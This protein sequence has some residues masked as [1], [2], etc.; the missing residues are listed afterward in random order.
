MNLS[1]LLPAYNSER[2]LEDALDSVLQQSHTT[3]ELLAIDDGSTD[4]TAQILERYAAK[5]PRIRVLS[6]PNWGMGASLNHALAEAQYDW[7]VRMDADDVMLPDR[8]ERQ[9]AFVTENPDVMVASCLVRY[10]DANGQIVGSYTSDITT[11]EVFQRHLRENRIIGFH[12]PGVIMKKDVVLAV[13]GYRPQYWSA[14]DLDLWNRIS[15]RGHLMLVQPEYLM[16]YRVHGS[17][18]SHQ[19]ARDQHMKVRWVEHSM[20][21]RRA[22]KS[23]YSLEEFQAEERSG[24]PVQRFNLRRKDTGK[25][26]YKAATLHYSSGRK[27]KTVLILA[28]AIACFPSYCLLELNKKFL[29]VTLPGKHKTISAHDG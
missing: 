28:G 13:G 6:H 16:K 8:L 25:I 20:L 17:S 24:H 5:D 9:V 15:E 1:I 11:R 3:F 7:I 22:G 18:V 21:R 27:L 4:A 2:W 12:H 23:E 10:I 19:A 29:H 26:L 14:D